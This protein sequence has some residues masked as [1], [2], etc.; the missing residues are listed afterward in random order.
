MNM[1]KSIYLFSMLLSLALVAGCSD[2]GEEPELNILELESANVSFDA[3]GG[4]GDIV[5]KSAG[6][7]AASSAAT[8][9][10]AAVSGN[11]VTVTVP[12]CGELLGRVTVVTVVSGVKKVQVPVMQSGTKI[13]CNCPPLAISNKAYDT[14]LLFNAPVPVTVTSSDAWLV[15]DISGA[16]L[17]IHAEA[18]P[19][20]AIREGTLT[21]SAGSFTLPITVTQQATN[22]KLSLTDYVG[23]W[24][25]TH[26]FSTFMGGMQDD[27]TAIVAASEGDTLR[28]TISAGTA[29]SATF[30]FFMN[31][32]AATGKVNIPLQKVF[33]HGANNVLLSGYNGSKVNTTVGNGGLAGMPVDGTPANPVVAFTDNLTGNKAYTYTGFVLWQTD[34]ASGANVDEYTGFGY[35]STSRYMNITMTK[36]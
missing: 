25:F 12:A 31:Y 24:T 8:W 21:L 36:Q 16:T 27:K 32:S 33:E 22:G 30:T 35:V 17:R 9:C 26:T 6:G 19:T 29:E 13:E 2:W 10:T 20:F 4:A 15:P 34:K 28:V 5:V 3:Y 23:T 18:N 11:K 14:T 1:K 7:I